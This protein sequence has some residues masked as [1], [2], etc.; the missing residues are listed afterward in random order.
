MLLLLLL[1]LFTL[2]TAATLN[3]IISPSAISLFDL[4]LAHQLT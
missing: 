3:G 1:L 2:I 4:H